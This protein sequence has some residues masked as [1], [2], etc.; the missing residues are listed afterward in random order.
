ML[1]KVIGQRFTSGRDLFALPEG[2]P[3]GIR[4]MT[5]IAQQVTVGNAKDD[6][7]QMLDGSLADQRLNQFRKD[8]MHQAANISLRND[9]IADITI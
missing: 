9:I 5:P 6:N 2:V 7:S 1:E 4:R 8:E 3:K